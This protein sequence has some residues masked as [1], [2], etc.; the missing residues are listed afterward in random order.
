MRVF[1]FLPLAAIGSAFVI[2]DQEIFSSVAV[3]DRKASSGSI[4]DSLPGPHDAWET[5]EETVSKAFKGAKD[6]WDNAVHY[7]EDIAVNIDNDFQEAFAGDPWL[8]SAD[9]DTDLF[10][11]SLQYGTPHHGPHQPGKPHHPP[12]HGKPNRTV[13]ELINESK[14]TTKLAKLI[15]EDEELVKLLNSTA[16][17]FTVFAPIDLA[18]EKIPEH[19]KKPS[20]EFIK[21]LLTYHVSTD[22]YPAGRVLVSRTIPTALG[23]EYLGDEPQ[24]L[25]TQISFKGLTV[26]FYSRVVAIDIFGTNGVIHGIDSVLLPPPKAVDIISLLPGEFSTLELGLVKT[27]L[28]EPLNDTSSHIGGTLFAPSNF[29]FQSLGPRINGFLFS[30]Y[31]EKYLKALLKYHAV[32]NYTLYSDAFY[33]ASS[34]DAKT[35]DCHHRPGVPK[36]VFHVDLPTLLDDRSLGIDVARYGRFVSIR[37]NGFTRVVVPDGIAA[38]GVIHV[39]P[40]VLI[41]PKKLGGADVSVEGM[42]LDEFKDRLEPF[43]EGGDGEN[44]SVEL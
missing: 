31:G 41:P 30:K 7:A 27:G 42:D 18:F 13:Y 37:I 10:D 9:Y 16:A 19:H 39:V 17:N 25:S 35:E 8:E 12:H 23:G 32:A 5:A 38:D 24:R 29:A 34:E 28:L 22:F 3:E 2:P 43:V 1:Y 15:N 33:K 6:T 14:Y 21:K 26:N 36:G 20:K 44:I 4:L 40:N 11:G